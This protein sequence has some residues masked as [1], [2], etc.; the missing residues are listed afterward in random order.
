[1]KEDPFFRKMRAATVESEKLI[2]G[3]FYFARWPEAYA[4]MA[5]YLVRGVT[6]SR[7]G[8]GKTLSEAAQ[9]AHEIAARA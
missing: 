9:K 3:A 6:G 7:D 1:V 4:T 5:D 8:I 2:H